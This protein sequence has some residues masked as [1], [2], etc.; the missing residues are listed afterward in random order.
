M[1]A[2]ELAKVMVDNLASTVFKKICFY[3]FFPVCPTTLSSGEVLSIPIPMSSTLLME[4]EAA[5]VGRDWVGALFFFRSARVP[6]NKP[7]SEGE[8][9]KC[10]KALDSSHQEKCQSLTTT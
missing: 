7:Q 2:T 8:G 1:A 10:A 4:W 3:A 5:P 9:G 6:K